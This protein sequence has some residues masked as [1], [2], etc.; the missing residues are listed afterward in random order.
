MKMLK[1][2]FSTGVATA[3]AVMLAV[4]AQAQTEDRRTYF[5]FDQPVTLPGVTLPAGKYLFRIADTTTTR[6]V[7]QV[8][9]A[10]GTESYAMVLTIPA[11]RVDPAPDAEVRFMEAPADVPRAI[12]SWW[13]PG[14]SIGYELVYPRDQAMRLAE[15]SGA[16]VLT[17]AEN[18]GEAAEEL[19]DAELARVGRG[20]AQTAVTPEDRPDAQEVAGEAHRGE[21]ARDDVAIAADPNRTTPP[22]VTEPRAPVGTAGREPDAPVAQ[23]PAGQAQPPAQPAQPGVRRELPRTASTLPALMLFGVLALGGGA[24]LWSFAR[25]RG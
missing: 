21:V 12:Q 17:T 22:Q 9:N 15:T 5:T 8:L 23:A 16:P 3:L 19:R 2:T 11:Q 13:Y 10:E 18:R 14:T 6:R 20:G 7:V 24:W 1:T 25:S 4:P